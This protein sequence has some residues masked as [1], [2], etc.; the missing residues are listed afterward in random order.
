MTE[1]LADRLRHFCRLH[2]LLPVSTAK[3]TWASPGEQSLVGWQLRSEPLL[4][5]CGRDRNTIWPC[6]IPHSCLLLLNY[7]LLRVVSHGL[8]RTSQKIN[9]IICLFFFCRVKGHQQGLHFAACIH[10][11]S[12]KTWQKRAKCNQTSRC[13]R[14]YPAL[15]SQ[16]TVGVLF[17]G[18]QETQLTGSA[19]PLR[20]ADAS[21]TVQP[22]PKT[23]LG[24]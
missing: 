22:L 10:F 24:S 19:H 11:T 3:G 4:I 23:W 7:R 12:F 1:R 13:G 15:W 17:A 21:E 9:C 8:R 18:E 14:Y 20:P 5:C 6:A 2:S 16:V